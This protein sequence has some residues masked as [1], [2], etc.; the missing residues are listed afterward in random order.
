MCNLDE[1]VM[2]RAFFK[3]SKAIEDRNGCYPKES[4]RFMTTSTFKVIKSAINW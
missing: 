2:F 3:Y 1:N 4:N